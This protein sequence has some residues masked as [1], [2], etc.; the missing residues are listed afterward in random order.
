MFVKDIGLWF[1][2]IMYLSGFDE[3]GWSQKKL[4]SGP[5]SS[6]FLKKT[7]ISAISSLDV[8]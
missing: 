3:F 8:W 2:F 6:Y 1:F 7:K 5:Y 4:G